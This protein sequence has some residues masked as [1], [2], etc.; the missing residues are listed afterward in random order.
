[1]W[2]QVGGPV[3]MAAAWRR[4]LEAGEGAA[5]DGEGKG[6]ETDSGARDGP[7]DAGGC[8]GRPR[9]RG[10][11]GGVD[12]EVGGVYHGGSGSRIPV[13]SLKQRGGSTCCAPACSQSKKVYLTCLLCPRCVSVVSCRPCLGLGLGPSATG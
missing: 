12:R 1:M 5:K 3:A 4:R 8:G 7:S 11:R 10:R 2:A 6:G 9:R 13:P